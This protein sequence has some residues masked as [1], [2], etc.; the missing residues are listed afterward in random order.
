MN[1]ARQRNAREFVATVSREDEQKQ[2]LFKELGFEITGRGEDF[3]LDGVWLRALPEGRPVAA[4]KMTR[5]AA[6]G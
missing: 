4:L 5:D 6:T 2:K 1:W 3:F